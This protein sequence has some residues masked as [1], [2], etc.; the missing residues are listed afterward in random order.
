MSS[1]LVRKLLRDMRVSLIVVGLLLFAFALMVCKSTQQGLELFQ[2]MNSR[3]FDMR[4]LV[5]TFFSSE[6]GKVI[7]KLI[8][9][10]K[11]TIG[12]GL[13]SLSIGYVHPLLLTILSVWAVGRAAGA[14]AGELDKGTMELLLAQPLARWR[15]IGSHFVVDCIAI[16]V[17]CGCLWGGTALGCHVFG[18]IEM[19]AKDRQPVDPVLFGPALSTSQR[20]C[21]RSAATRWRS[22]QWA[23][24]HPRSRNRRRGD[25]AAVLHQPAWANLAGHPIS[26]ALDRLLLLPAAR[27]DI[28]LRWCIGGRGAKRG[29]FGGRGRC[30]VCDSPGSLLPPRFAGA[31]VTAAGQCY[32]SGFTK[33]LA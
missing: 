4:L 18:L 2:T 29:D 32:N 12:E 23:L 25:I 3:G 27:A 5:R 15:V 26:A 9:G 13:D 22:H 1:T 24:P 20:D 7:A 14:I 19:T 6:S 31:V 16:P 17:L 21:L 30:G 10:D 8:G 33:Q 11:I 28:G